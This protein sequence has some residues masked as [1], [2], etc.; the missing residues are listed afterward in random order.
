LSC[1]V[2]CLC[3]PSYTK[4]AREQ[5]EMEEYLGTSVWPGVQRERLMVL[6]LVLHN[7]PFKVRTVA[8]LI[9]I[10]FPAE[11][12]MRKVDSELQ[13]RAQPALTKAELDMFVQFVVKN[14]G[15]DSS[16]IDVESLNSSSIQEPARQFRRLG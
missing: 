8:D 5:F 1:V 15:G 4:R 10:T 13:R 6:R 7:T 14:R 12:V 16:F 3:A 9:K 11:S 2:L